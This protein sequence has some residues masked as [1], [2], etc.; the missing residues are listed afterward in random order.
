MVE[1]MFGLQPQFIAGRGGGT[2]ACKQTRWLQIKPPLIGKKYEKGN[3]FCSLHTHTHTNTQTHT[4]H[5]DLCRL[6]SILSLQ[7]DKWRG[8]SVTKT[9]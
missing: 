6:I 9:D 7:L 4:K 1:A 2:G 5:T 8:L 3:E